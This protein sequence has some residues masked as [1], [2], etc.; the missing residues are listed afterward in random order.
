MHITR[1]G[2]S[3]YA[4]AARAHR[5]VCVLRQLSITNKLF[6]HILE[7]PN[8]TPFYT[9]LRN[10]VRQT[11]KQVAEKKQLTHTH[12]IRSAHMSCSCEAAWQ[13]EKPLVYVVF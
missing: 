3:A 7:P 1:A 5:R 8:S 12:I 9:H 6:P 4:Y 10:E 13:P 11:R 2:R